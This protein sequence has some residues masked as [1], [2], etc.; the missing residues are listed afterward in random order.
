MGRP[1]GQ[2]TTPQFSFRLDP[3]LR[4]GL[5]RLAAAEHRNLSNYVSLVLAQH[6]TQKTR[7]RPVPVPVRTRPPPLLPRAQGA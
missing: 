4:A 1:K 3:E 5:E 2:G 7:K 6:V